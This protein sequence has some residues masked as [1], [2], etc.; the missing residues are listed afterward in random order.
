[1]QITGAS[2]DNSESIGVSS[3]LTEYVKFL[4]VNVPLPTFYSEPELE[5][6][7]GTSLEAA[8]EAKLNNLTKE[9]EVLRES[10]EGIPWCRKIWWHEE[11]GIL[12]IN[13]WKQVDAWYRS[14][15]LDLPGTGHA[16]VPCVDMA[17]HA[18][19]DDTS[20]LYETSQDGDAVLQLRDTKSLYIGEEVTIT[21][22]DEKGACEMLF[23]YGFIE[24]SMKS[25]RELFLELEIPD[26]DPLKLAK[27]RISNCPPGFKLF[28]SSDKSGWEGDF[29]W[30]S[31]VNEED[32]LTFS[33][34]R[35]N[36]GE[37]ELKVAWKN[38]EIYDTANLKAAL[39]RD[40]LWDIFQLRA[41]VLL[42][43]RLDQQMT[44]LNENTG[45]TQA[46][47]RDRGVGYESWTNISRLRELE[48]Q[49]LAKG[50]QDFEQQVRVFIRWL[51]IKETRL[52]NNVK[53]EGILA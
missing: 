15:A 27:L 11:K 19:G 6:L 9:F 12:S 52:R 31:C 14:R 45:T 53:L 10:T 18:S 48:G 46:A 34:L 49:L 28:D 43:A 38:E 33:V 4:P 39:Q 51:F 24:E 47:Q 7:H 26:D 42:Q 16:M 17:N 21:Y 25:A 20:A 36:D 3:P 13:D 30:W 41:I 35:T 29:V 44:K 50:Y 8:L 40:R 32:G 23:S 2:P 5:L 22:G 1:M 37:R